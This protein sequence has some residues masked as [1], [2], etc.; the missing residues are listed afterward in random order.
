MCVF[1]FSFF[2]FFSAFK[3]RMSFAHII[4]TSSQKNEKI[5]WEGEGVFL[6][7]NKS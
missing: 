6:K 7:K 2:F 5:R 4:R 1:F 3:D